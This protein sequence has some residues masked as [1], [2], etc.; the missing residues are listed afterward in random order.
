MNTLLFTYIPRKMKIEFIYLITL[1]LNALPDKS[2]VSETFSLREI[3]LHWRMD[4]K[5]TV[6]Y[7]LAHTMRYMT[8]QTPLIP[9]RAVLTKGHPWD[10]P[11]IYKAA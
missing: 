4:T 6:E 1:W 9:L 2:G 7:F 8:S 5:S 3:L 10:Q 11:E